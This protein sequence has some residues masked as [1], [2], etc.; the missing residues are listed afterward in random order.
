MKARFDSYEGFHPR[1]KRGGL[2]H[3][4]YHRGRPASTRY[5]VEKYMADEGRNV[6]FDSYD[7][8]PPTQAF[9]ELA[10]HDPAQH[11]LLFS[12]APG[13]SLDLQ[14][15][16]REVMQWLG[17]DHGQTPD[18]LAALHRDSAVEHAHVLLRGRDQDGHTLSVTP[19]YV[20]GPL[21]ERAEAAAR[22]M[23]SE[24]YTRERY[25][26]ELPYAYLV[27]ANEREYGRER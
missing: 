26:V 5:F 23:S 3:T 15:L 1:L 18:Y 24:S 25:S 2:V 9:I 10:Q 12:P 19:A 17:E 16:T 8:E 4:G 6:L 7:R 14:M 21:R 22:Q 13:Q 11:L 20:H 27:Q